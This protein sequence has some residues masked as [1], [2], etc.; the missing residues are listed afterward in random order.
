[1]LHT[2]YKKKKKTGS[3]RT[4][5]MLMHT[6]HLIHTLTFLNRKTLSQVYN[7]NT[8]YIYNTY[9]HLYNHNAFYLK[10]I[11]HDMKLGLNITVSHVNH[12]EMWLVQIFNLLVFK[13]YITVQ[14]WHSKKR[15]L[16]YTYLFWMILYMA[17]PTVCL[18]QHQF[19]TEKESLFHK[20]L[21]ACQLC[22]L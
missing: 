19:K 17:E 7:L 21:S 12:H 11:Q 2:K 18:Q 1:M 6:H 15:S 10:A 13:K 20:H 4:I 8:F 9:Y 22:R 14:D 3:A 16:C 5:V